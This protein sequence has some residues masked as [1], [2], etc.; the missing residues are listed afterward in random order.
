MGSLIKEAQTA[1]DFKS[2]KEFK[3]M[4]NAFKQM[5]TT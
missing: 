2:K 1:R 5:I 4:A 3:E